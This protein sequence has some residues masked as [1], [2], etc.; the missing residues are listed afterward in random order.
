M[1]AQRTGAS[2]TLYTVVARRAEVFAPIVGRDAE[3]AFLA[4]SARTRRAALEAA[5]ASMPEGVTAD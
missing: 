3:E 4:T 1:L 2:L 5:L